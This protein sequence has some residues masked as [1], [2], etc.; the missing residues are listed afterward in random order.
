MYSRD[1]TIAWPTS[2]KSSGISR[3]SWLYCSG[4]IYPSWAATFAP[5]FTALAQIPASSAS[6]SGG[7]HFSASFRNCLWASSVFPSRLMIRPA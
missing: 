6:S 1:N 2:E 4:G 7:L 3:K 5:N